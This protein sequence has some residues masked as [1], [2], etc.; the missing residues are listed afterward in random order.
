MPSVFLCFFES[1]QSA[2]TI[3][4]RISC[5]DQS[6]FWFP[7]TATEKV[8]NCRIWNFTNCLFES[9]KEYIMFIIIVRRNQNTIWY[10]I[11]FALMYDLREQ[12]SKT[13]FWWYLKISECYSKRGAKFVSQ[14]KIPNQLR[15]QIII[16]LWNGRFDMWNFYQICIMPIFGIK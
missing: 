16:K 1:K 3:L 4:Y 13:N 5:K 2:S 11:D 12:D 8:M 10:Q 7:E 14:W 9:C 15:Y 6:S